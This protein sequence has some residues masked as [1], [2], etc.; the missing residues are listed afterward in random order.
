MTTIQ[1]IILGIIQGITEF[2]PVSS[3]GHL[4]LMQVLFGW[5]NLSQFI[6]FD[7]T[8]HLGTLLSIFFVLRKEIFS[9]LTKERKE[10]LCFIVALIPLLPLYV[11]LKQIHAIY[12]QPKLL[13]YFFILTSLLLFIGDRFSKKD[14]MKG[15]KTPFIIGC[16]QA[17]AILPGVSR[18][19][20]TIA[21]ARLL[22][23][24]YERAFRFSFLLAIPTIIGG[25]L[26]ECLSV[27]KQGIVVPVGNLQYTLGFFFSFI[28]G[29]FA[30]KVLLKILQ[31][32]RIVIFVWY[33]LI[34]GILTLVYTHLR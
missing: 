7:I 31:K 8:C 23:W 4:K 16:F 20:S 27:M 1:A 3:S 10:I 30:L 5:D 2:F 13:G 28:V 24:S 33:C 19:G 11:L 18:S 12:D 9:L 14:P 6:L 22:G 15:Y 21:S 17:L 25:T 32:Q 29:V 34:L 26:V